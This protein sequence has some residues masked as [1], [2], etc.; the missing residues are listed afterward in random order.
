MCAQIQT[1]LTT[2]FEEYKDCVPQ[3]LGKDRHGYSYHSILN[4]FVLMLLRGIRSEEGLVEYL[5]EHIDEAK[6]CGFTKNIPHRTTLGRFRKRLGSEFIEKVHSKMLSMQEIDVIN[7]LADS[8]S[9]EKRDDKEAKVGYS[10]TKGLYKGF[11]AHIASDADMRIPLLLAVTQANRHDGPLLPHLMGKVFGMRYR[12]TYAITDAGYDG[13]E[14]HKML[15]KYGILPVI[16]LNKRNL[17]SG[18]TEKFWSMRL[19]PEV[20]RGSKLYK[21]LQSKRFAAEEV[22]SALKQLI[23]TQRLYVNGLRNIS[24]YVYLAS[25][26]ITTFYFASANCSE[27]DSPWKVCFLRY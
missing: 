2:V 4:A 3:G 8:T 25:L 5:N 14:N 23:N 18:K 20:E 19:N 16:P 1:I 10:S 26:V 9:L 12:P 6:L 21:K 27:I 7:V 24:F 22:N 13:E 15:K 11:K 17:R